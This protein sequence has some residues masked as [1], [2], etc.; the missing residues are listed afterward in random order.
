M[1]CMILA[2]MTRGRRL[3]G[4]YDR[5][6]AESGD[7]SAAEEADEKL[8]E[9]A[10]KETTAALNHVLMEASQQ[11]KNGYNRADN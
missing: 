7:F 5:K 9:M 8:C 6:M 3:I 1:A 4:E 2:V 11:M 10:R